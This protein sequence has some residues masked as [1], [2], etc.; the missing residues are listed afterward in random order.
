MVSGEAQNLE[1]AIA[2]LSD[3]KREFDALESATVNAQQKLSLVI[4]QLETLTFD[5]S[6]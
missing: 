2:Q 6:N 5:N 1:T 4:E 3:L